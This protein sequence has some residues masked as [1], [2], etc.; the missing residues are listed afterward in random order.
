MAV[1][2]PRDCRP[3]KTRPKKHRFEPCQWQGEE[4][5]HASLKSVLD[6]LG[7]EPRAHFRALI[8]KT[9]L[10]PQN[11]NIASQRIFDYNRRSSSLNWNPA[12]TVKIFSAAAAAERLEMLG[13]SSKAKVTFHYDKKPMTR[14]VRRLFHDAL[15][16]SD[17]VA[18]NQ[19]VEVA[20][21]RLLNGPDGTLGRLGLNDTQ[22]MRAYAISSWRKLGRRSSLRQAPKLSIVG[23]NGKRV[24]L[25][26][27]HDDH[28]YP[29]R[30][31]ACTTPSDL[32]K[33]MCKTVLHEQLPPQSRLRLSSD[34][35]RE[36]SLLSLFRQCLFSQ[37]GG[38]YRRRPSAIK[39]LRNRYF[40]EDQDYYIY[41]KAGYSLGW[42]SENIVI[43]D[44]RLRQFWTITIAA[45]GG[46]NG[47][48]ARKI[49]DPAVDYIARIISE[50]WL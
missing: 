2:V 9:T 10:G 4:V 29:C 8:V 3:P 20:G 41:R 11:Q 6:R 28:T 44:L 24:D 18:H 42:R 38:R 49:L 45:H 27:T 14:T 46:K 33:M 48:A 12:S 19:L 32:A 13:F 21:F 15:H 30:K 25:P 50:G 23:S 16:R 1:R 22:V 39:S 34:T 5:D 37:C 43:E 40:H 17:N 26:A 47:R 36:H 31:A 35:N 7:F